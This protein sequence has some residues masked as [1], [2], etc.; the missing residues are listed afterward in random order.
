MKLCKICQIEKTLTEFSKRKDRGVSSLSTMCKPCR[1]ARDREKYKTGGTSN[2]YNPDN[3]RLLVYA[4]R[5]KL[6][7]ASGLHR[8]A[9]IVGDSRRND[10][11][12]GRDNDLEKEF[13]ERLISTGCSYCGSQTGLMTLD[14]LDNSKGHLQSNV[15]AACYRCNLLKADMPAAAWAKLVPAIKEIEREGLFGDWRKKKGGDRSLPLSKH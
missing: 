6:V 1:R 10:R 4:E 2:R 14:R 8:A 5:A 3:P 13:V 9:N 11:Q 7:R 12:K 15:V